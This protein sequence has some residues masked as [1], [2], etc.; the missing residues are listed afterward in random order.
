MITKEQLIRF[1][2]SSYQHFKLLEKG[3]YTG[4]W[5]HLAPMM[6]TVG[7]MV[8]SSAHGQPITRWCYPGFVESFLAL[9]EWDGVGDPPGDWIKQKGEGGDRHNPNLP[10]GD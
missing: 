1:S 2:H 8:S 3:P 5:A 7:I 9:Q 6:F 10:T 4:H